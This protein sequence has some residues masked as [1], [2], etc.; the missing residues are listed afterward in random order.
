[1]YVVR[2]VFAPATK[3][4]ALALQ[5]LGKGK[6]LPNTPESVE[7]GILGDERYALHIAALRKEIASKRQARKASV[8][9]FTLGVLVTPFLC[10]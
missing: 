8:G 6:A 4:T 10:V 7:H 9:A 1:M 3:T 2:C 5:G